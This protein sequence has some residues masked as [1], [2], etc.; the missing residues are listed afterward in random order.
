MRTTTIL[1]RLGDSFRHTIMPM[2]GNFAAK[3]RI[4][5]GVPCRLAP[6]PPW[7]SSL[8]YPFTFRR[9]IHELGPDL[10]LTYN[11]GSMDAFV[12]AATLPRLPVIHGEDGFGPDEAVR[13]LR[14]RVWM[15]R[16]WLRRAHT[17]VVPSQRLLRI[18]LEQ[19]KLPASRVRFIANGIDTSVFTPGEN[20]GKRRDLGIPPDATVF[21]FVGRLGPEKNLGLLLRGFAAAQLPKAHLLMVGEGECAPELKRLTSE[22]GITERVIFTGGTV[23]PIEYYRTL[24]VFVMSSAT[25][26]A[27]MSL[28]EA[29]GCGLPVVCTDVG[30]M[31]FMLGNPGAETVTPADD[32]EAY[33]AALRRVYSDVE[34][35][36]RLGDANRR[37]CVENYSVE[38]M[39]NEYRQLYLSAIGGAHAN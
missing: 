22:L 33:A 37:R 12:G 10:V 26:Q 35:R 25:E 27:P 9:I 39:V 21:G 19:Y 5:P 2:D 3:T 8:R 14:R 38:T 29:M 18:A 13:L 36:R 20:P 1:N 34:L 30:D 28:L 4:A 7:Q 6:P 17:V 11:W 24:E 16:V 31:N 15:R 23:T 32:V